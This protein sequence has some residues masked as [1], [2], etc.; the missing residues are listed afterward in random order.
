[1]VNRFLALLPLL[2]TA[3]CYGWSDA[4]LDGV[5]DLKDAC[6][7]TPAGLEV[8][9]NG[10]S[11]MPLS[12][13]C[14]PT[15]TGAQYPSSCASANSLVVHFPS[16]SAELPQSQWPVLE[17]VSRFMKTYPGA[18]MLLAG[19][20]DA[21]GTDKV[22]LPLSLD[23]AELVRQVLIKDYQIDPGRLT[24]SGEGSEAPVASNLHIRGK[25]LNRRV[26]FVIK[27]E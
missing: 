6:A 26:E 10:C 11:K 13:L 16:G 18:H 1:M 23:R 15:D 4:D 3:A 20:T 2:M 25:Y 19:H 9:A 14:L 22:N 27:S 8:Y 5:P 7:D 12:E 24:V 21:A 17:Q